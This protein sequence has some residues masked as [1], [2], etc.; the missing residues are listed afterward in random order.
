MPTINRRTKKKRDYHSASP[1]RK[2]RIKYYGSTLW[3]SIRSIKLSDNP[4]CEVCLSNGIITPADSVH[5]IHSPFTKESDDDVA[6]LFYDP[7]NLMSICNVCHGHI[8]SNQD[9]NSLDTI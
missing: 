7:T 2:K 4:L 5:H 8:H 9:V 1:T 3:R 6:E